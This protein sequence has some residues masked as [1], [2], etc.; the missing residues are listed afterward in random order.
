MWISLFYGVKSF[1]YHFATISNVFCKNLVYSLQ[2]YN[3]P[4]IAS[5]S[6]LWWTPS[7]GWALICYFYIFFQ[8]IVSSSEVQDWN[9]CFVTS[10]FTCPSPYMYKMVS[11]SLSQHKLSQLCRSFTP[12][13]TWVTWTTHTLPPIQAKSGTN[14]THLLNHHLVIFPIIKTIIRLRIWSISSILLPY[15]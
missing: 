6:R 12:T 11:K 4:W 9:L 5:N 1:I 15:S 13:L 7:Q 3:F 14:W 10:F 8:L 2:I